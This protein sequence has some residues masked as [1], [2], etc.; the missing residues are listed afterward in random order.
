VVCPRTGGVS[1]TPPAAHSPTVVDSTNGVRYTL[2]SNSL[3]Q[4][5]NYQASGTSANANF[6]VWQISDVYQGCGA[7]DRYGV[8]GDGNNQPYLTFPEPGYSLSSCTQISQCLKVRVVTSSI[9][10]YNFNL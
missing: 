5:V 6:P 3:T 7:F 9:R 10:L 2:L 4:V 8:S 1:I